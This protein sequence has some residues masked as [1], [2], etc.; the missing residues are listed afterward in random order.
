MI[1]EE[2]DV[3]FEARKNLNLTQQQVADIAGVT[4]RHYRLF[5]NGERKLTSASFLTASGVLRA[6][7][8]DLTS[9]ANGVYTSRETNE[10]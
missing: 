10:K 7:N 5:E 6:L 8:L 4:V 2:K 3:L 1:R 9:F